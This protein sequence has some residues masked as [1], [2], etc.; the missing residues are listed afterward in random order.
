MFWHISK[1]FL[2]LFPCSKHDTIFLWHSL[3]EPSRTLGNK[4]LQGMGIPNE[5]VVPPEFSQA[6]PH[7]ASSNSSVM[8]QVSLSQ[9]RCLC[10]F[11]LVGFLSH[12]LWIYSPVGFSNLGG[13]IWYYDLTCL[14]AL[15]RI[16]DFSVCCWNET[17]TPRLL[18]AGLETGSCTHFFKEYFPVCRNLGWYFFSLFNILKI[19]FQCLLTPIFYDVSFH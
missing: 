11:V 4:T 1:W 7:W 12:K 16:V 5:W 13:S 15:R 2:F 14:E 3:R 8:I 18:T 6:C 19:S 9:H 17:T 10:S